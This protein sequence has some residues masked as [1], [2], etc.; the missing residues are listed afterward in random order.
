MGRTIGLVEA[1]VGEIEDEELGATGTGLFVLVEAEP[2]LRAADQF[3]PT[4]TGFFAVGTAVAVRRLLGPEGS[5][6]WFEVVD[7]EGLDEGLIP[8]GFPTDPAGI[9]N[10]FGSG[11]G[12][13]FGMEARDGGSGTVTD[14][15]TF[16]RLSNGT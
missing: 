1:E 2:K 13:G 7:R 15:C 14:G 9:Y 12:E 10:S 6:R 11:G 4:T 16:R 8:R 5:G 3:A